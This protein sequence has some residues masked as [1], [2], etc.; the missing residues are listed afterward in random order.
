MSQSTAT[1]RDTGLIWSEP[2]QMAHN[3]WMPDA[4][5]NE[6]NIDGSILSVNVS[7][8]MD[9]CAQ[10]TAVIHDPGFRYAKANYFWVT[11]DV[12]YR[13]HSLVSMGTASNAWESKYLTQMMEIGSAKLGPSSGTGAQWTCQM[14]TKAIQQMK[15]GKG[16][17]NDTYGVAGQIAGA[18]HTWVANAAAMYGLKTILEE[19]DKSYEPKPFKSGDEAAESSS[20]WDV[21]KGIANQDNFVVFEADGILFCCSHQF[22]LGAWG[23]ETGEKDVLNAE[24]NQREPRVVRYVPVRWPRD[25]N[26]VIQMM[27]MPS[28]SKSDND[29]FAVQGSMVVDRTNG[30]SLRPGMTILLQGIPMFGPLLDGS[31]PSGDSGLYL[32]SSVDF[33]HLGT[34]PVR[35][36]FR[37]PTRKKDQIRNYPVGMTRI[38]PMQSSASSGKSTI[39]ATFRTGISGAPAWQG[40]TGPR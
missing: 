27:G 2:D 4:H 8:S 39:P 17:E 26:A 10:V 16:D 6:S 14:R 38:E 30:T 7:Y 32:I 18:G 34:K 19:T 5:T 28:V 37:S 1:A 11:R 24:T 20:V 13:S 31:S 12:W 40:L 22:L 36:S 35:V 21:I 15:R 25:P 33:D 23:I 3:Q 9:L 29:P